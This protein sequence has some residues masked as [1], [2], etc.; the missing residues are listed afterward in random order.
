MS[1]PPG[2]LM[3]ALV[4]TAPRV[5]EMQRLPVPRPEPGEVLLA[6]SAAGICGSE[7][8][9]YLGESSIR[10]PPLVMGHEAAGT[11]VADADASLADGSP[12]RAGTRVA[13]NP[14]VVCGECDRCRAGRS[15]VC[16]NRKLI[17]AHRPG[18]YAPYVAVPAAL[19]FPLPAHVSEV[20]GSLTEPL[21][22]GVRA[23]SL[24]GPAER[25]VVL[26]A[27]PI[28]LCCL[29]AARAAGVAQVLVSDI[30]PRRLEVAR[31]WG[32][33]ATVNVRQDDLL[34]AVQE[35]APG[36]ADA[37]VDAVGTGVTR[38][39]A[40]RA[41]VPGGRVVFLGLHDE[42]A[43]LHA[44]YIVRQEI[45]VQGSF[46]YTA[47]DFARAFE[48][49]VAGAIPLDG[50]WLEERPLAEGPRAF[51]ELLAGQAAATKIVLRVTPTEHP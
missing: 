48:L 20:A 13:F 25:L 28:G 24:A 10:V 30:S 6:V 22:C 41:V 14:L 37:V 1:T 44:N 39:Q 38:D 49:I 23:V 26:G 34:A 17:G 19:C 11:I 7:L 16:R 35:F 43:T 33:A 9:G 15:S 8:S 46:A 27:G 32:A 5:M 12:A 4:W 3:E 36:G 47:A 45:A 18:A 51:E 2:E 21:A 40:V 29:V 42:N 50:G 31:A